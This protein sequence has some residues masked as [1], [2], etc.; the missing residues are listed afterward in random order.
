[1]ITRRTIAIGSGAVIGG[2]LFVA[3]YQAIAHARAISRG[4]GSAPDFLDGA[5]GTFKVH[6]TGYWPST[7][8]EDERKMEGKN[9]DRIGA[10]L[11]TLEDFIAGRSDHVSLSGDLDIFPY[12]QLLLIH[13]WPGVPNLRGRVTDTG[14]HFFNVGGLVK[15]G[16][17]SKVIRVFS[18]EPLDFDV[19]SSKTFVPKKGITATIVPGD[20]W[21][22]RTKKTVQTVQTDKIQ[23]DGLIGIDAMVARAA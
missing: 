1:M 6:A 10:P 7:A 18:E 20:H 3:L 17:A 23:R 15:R 21:A 2:G 8:R 11:H 13:G 4:V 5:G 16:K 22:S 14:G 12:G 19:E 9:K